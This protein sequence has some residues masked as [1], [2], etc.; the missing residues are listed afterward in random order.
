MQLIL[1]LYHYSTNVPQVVSTTLAVALPASNHQLALVPN[2]QHLNLRH[3]VRLL[4]ASQMAA[5]VTPDTVLYFGYAEACTCCFLLCSVQ[6]VLPFGH[7]QRPLQ[8][9]TW[10]VLGGFPVLHARLPLLQYHCMQYFTVLPREVS[11]DEPTYHNLSHYLTLRAHGGR[12]TEH[13][14]YCALTT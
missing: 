6:C 4:H 11:R 12:R 3:K 2:Q 7:P 5:A 10:Y 1:I 13:S 14:K 9:C 8:Y